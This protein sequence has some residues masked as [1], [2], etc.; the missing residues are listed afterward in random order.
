[1]K[2]LDPVAFQK[3][4]EELTGM[5]GQLNRFIEDSKKNL[6][7]RHS[8]VRGTKLEPSDEELAGTQN[9]RALQRWYER[10]NELRVYQ[11]KHGHC[12]VPIKDPKLGKVSKIKIVHFISCI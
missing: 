10:C 12:N 8:F 9:K 6:I 2:E 1:L 11:K 5:M 3:V 7:R 4:W